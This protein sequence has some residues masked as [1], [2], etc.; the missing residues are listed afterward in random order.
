[1]RVGVRVHVAH[2][3]LHTVYVICHASVY[4]T[5]LARYT[6]QIDIIYLFK[7]MFR[8]LFTACVSEYVWVVISVVCVCVCVVVHSPW[9]DSSRG[10]LNSMAWGFINLLRF[11][12]SW[13]W[14]N[15]AV[16]FQFSQLLH[17]QIVKRPSI[18]LPIFQIKTKKWILQ[19]YFSMI[20]A[21]INIQRAGR[22]IK[23]QIIFFY[24]YLINII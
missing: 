16:T 23:M 8:S 7:C 5:T 15:F 10:D 20:N 4:L 18:L 24:I 22:L 14:E 12:K 3:T 2:R 13:G 6:D 17:L 11:W 9:A 19:I 1:M 21:E